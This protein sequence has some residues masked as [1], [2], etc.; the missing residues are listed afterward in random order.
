MLKREKGEY[1]VFCSFRKEIILSTLVIASIILFFSKCAFSA[2]NKPSGSVNKRTVYNIISGFIYYDNGK[3][4]R[5]IKQFS[6][7]AGKINNSYGYYTLSKIYFSN[8]DFNRALLSINK[9]I[10]LENISL[11]KN[12]LS[13]DKI[14]Y[15]VLKAKILAAGNNIEASISLLKNI[16]KTNPA[17][18]KTLLL[19]ANIYIYN[20]DLKTAT[21][22]LDLI[23]L[24]HPGNM[25]VY[26]ILFKVHVSLNKKARAEKDLL[27]LIKIDP[28]FKKAY[29]ELSSIYIFSG[30]E[31]KAI[32]ILKKYLDVDPYS[33]NALYQTAALEYSVKNYGD[34]RKYFSDFLYIT[35][36]NKRLGDLRNNARFF[37]GI[38]YFLEKKNK[39]ALEN[40][41]MVSPGSHYTDAL[42]TE[43]E[44]YLIDFNKTKSQSDKNKIE[45][46]VLM[47]IKDKSVK[48]S[49]KTYYFS[50]IATADIKD[51]SRSKEIILE[52]LKYYPD[53]TRMLYELGSIYHSL[54]EESAASGI[55]DRILKIDPENADALNYLGYYLAV[56]NTDLNRA[57]LLIEKALS[58]QKDSP[59]IQD[60][61]GFVLYRFKKYDDALKYFEEALKGLSNSAT[62]L[63]HAGMDYFELKNYKK[64]LEYLT[65]S[66][67]TKKDKEVGDYIKKIDGILRK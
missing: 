34:A 23:K 9:A 29:F 3:Y 2:G 61:M 50:A 55:M 65:K 14:N 12:R 22:Y 35:K 52:G 44:I 39:K 5:A 54:K 62:V 15:L 13:G 46:T 41:G 49:I 40:L 57:R 36:K 6:E 45:K 30:K 31:N 19:L 4:D 28:Y 51:Y 21:E 37:T 17:N 11:G 64:A 25:D 53:N 32:E 18:L 20:N 58:I 16:L 33:K 63:K 48:K 43:I 27:S 59:Y 24:N 67:K 47:L 8:R 7:E 60:S 1:G 56:K 26:Y 66:Y 42:L 10:R 38:S